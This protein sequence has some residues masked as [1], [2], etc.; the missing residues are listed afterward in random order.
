MILI[1]EI[2]QIGDDHES[3]WY[4]RLIKGPIRLLTDGEYGVEADNPLAAKKAMK[5]QLKKDNAAKDNAISFKIYKG[6]RFIWVGRAVLDKSDPTHLW[7]VIKKEGPWWICHSSWWHSPEERIHVEKKFK[8]E[9]LI[10]ANELQFHLNKGWLTSKEMNQDAMDGPQK[11]ITDGNLFAI[12][13]E[14]ND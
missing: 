11:R 3:R 7:Y 13:E 14:Q 2:F 1:A 6:S 12:N 8:L 9:H 5:R 10:P 4:C